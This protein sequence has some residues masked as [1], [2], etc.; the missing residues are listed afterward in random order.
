MLQN[1]LKILKKLKFRFFLGHL[2]YLDM[3]LKTMKKKVLE[4]FFKQLVQN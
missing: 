1:S 2:I 3:I 4:S